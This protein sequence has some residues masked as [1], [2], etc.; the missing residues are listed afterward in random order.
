MMTSNTEKL[1]SHRN[2]RK[3]ILVPL[4]EDLLLSPVNIETLED[5]KWLY[6]LA[7][8][9]GNREQERNLKNYYSPS[10]L[11]SCIRQVYLSRNHK[12]LGIKRVRKVGVNLNYIFSLGNWTHIRLQFALYKLNKKLPNEIFK[13]VGVEVHAASKHGDHGGTIDAIAFI[14]GEPFVI[15]FKGLN[16]RDF[17]RVTMNEVPHQYRIQIADYIMLA[18]V[19]KHI[20]VPTIE[21]GLLVTEN[22]GGPDAKYPIA[23]YET[24]IL[25]ADHR[26]ELLA[27]L[28]TLRQHEKEESIPPPACES[29]KEI[30]FTACP[31][32][33]YCRAEVKNIEDAKGSDTAG[34]SI[35]VSTPRGNSRSRRS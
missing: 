7:M 34:D 19:D 8:R 10:A 28:E 21:R 33:G 15:D 31:F 29:T 25:L 27:R 11:A 35:R 2:R 20:K 23:L 13:L 6:A 32:S 9:Q 30:Q 3:G 5:S 22:K 18:N 24:E 16:V 26:P 12:Q 1:L 17:G 14:Y 4:L